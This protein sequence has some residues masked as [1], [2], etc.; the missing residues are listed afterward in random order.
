MGVKRMRILLCSVLMVLSPWACSPRDE[1]TVY[2]LV[3]RDESVEG[4]FCNEGYMAGSRAVYRVFPERQ[5]VVRWHITRW[6]VRERFEK[7]VIGNVDNWHCWFN[8]DSGLFGVSNGEF[9]LVASNK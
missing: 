8:D 6:S 5:E 9:F 2:P 3:C 1:V 7:C 4:P